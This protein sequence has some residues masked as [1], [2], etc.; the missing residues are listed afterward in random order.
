MSKRRKQPLSERDVLLA[1][2]NYYRAMCNVFRAGVRHDEWSQKLTDT[3]AK[4][5]QMEGQAQ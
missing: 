1:Q 3:L 4:L 5:D 2:A